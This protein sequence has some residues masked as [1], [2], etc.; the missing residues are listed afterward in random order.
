MAVVVQCFKCNAILELDDGFR[1]GVCRCGTCGTLLQ[2]PKG[3]HTTAT[4]RIARPA[5]P[6][7][8]T[9]PAAP[10]VNP[11]S[12]NVETGQSSGK[13]DATKVSAADL[14]GSSSGLAQGQVHRTKPI[15]HDKPRKTPPTD[16]T[17]DLNTAL[18]EASE[19]ETTLPPHIM[20]ARAP[21][22]PHGGTPPWLMMLV[23]LA[24]AG[25]I[26]GLIYLYVRDV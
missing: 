26:A 9:R 13:F 19:K 17:P 2:V 4:A 25:V 10:V 7:A 11:P 14:G 21:E 23:L 15:S 16:N 3:D 20:P 12:P 22:A 8:P 1:G 24:T 5:G 6:P 18:Q